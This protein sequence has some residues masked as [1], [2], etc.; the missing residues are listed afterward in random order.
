MVLHFTFSFKVPKLGAIV[1]RQQVVEISI[2]DRT[3]V[4]SC[5]VEVEP[6]DR[7]TRGTVDRP[8]IF[9]ICDLCIYIL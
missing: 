3:R 5:L 1:K 9:F 2:W 6:T 7:A 4:T 8:F